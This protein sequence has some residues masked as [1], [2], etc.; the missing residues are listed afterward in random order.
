M[1]IL[2]EG[3]DG[4]GKST[5]ADAVYRKT[6][7]TATHSG[8]PPRGL[9]YATFSAVIDF[10]ETS[11][12]PT[13]MDR[14]HWGDVPYGYVHRGDAE[15]ELRGILDMNARLDELGAVIVYVRADADVINARI[16]ARGGADSKWE[17]PELMHRIVGLYDEVY[18]ASTQAHPGL[19]L[20]CDA[21]EFGDTD[22]TSDAIIAYAKQ[23]MEE[24]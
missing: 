22:E 17:D 23:R 24:S 12:A 9:A 4:T 13:V 7:A 5:L 1:I 8:P 2:F 6:S 11:P 10:A 16:T 15:L 14:L 20:F 18:A 19:V 21:N 3:P